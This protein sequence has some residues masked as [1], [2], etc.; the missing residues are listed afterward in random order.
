MG[1]D[2]PI[3]AYRPPGGGKLVFN[4]A[5]GIQNTYALQVPCGNC[6]GCKLEKA[7]QWMV[8]MVCESSLYDENCFVTLT[9]DDQH[10]PADYGLDARHVQL[11]F[12]RLRWTIAENQDDRRIRHYTAC[13]Y[14]GKTGRP[15]YHPIIFNWWPPDATFHFQ[16]KFG[17]HVYKSSILTAT[18]G[19]GDVTVGRVTPRSCGYVARYVTKKIKGNDDYAHDHYHRLSPIDGQFYNVTPEFALMSSKPGIGYNWAKKFKHDY[20]P[21]GFITI[22]GKKQGAPQFFMDML[23]DEEK[24]EVFH[25]RRRQ[26]VQPRSERFMERKIAREGVRNA[27]ITPLK[28]EL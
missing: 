22:D 6:M 17:D 7:R 3:K 23:S 18:W 20:Y 4:G 11:F 12:K 2:Y 5:K 25:F 15:H 10:V 24:R 19:M 13:E 16:N 9:Y 21:K 26:F 14:G 27:K 28:R 1:C 8:R